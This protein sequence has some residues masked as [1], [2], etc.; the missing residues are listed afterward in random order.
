MSGEN[1]KAVSPRGDATGRQCFLPG[2][3]HH[4]EKNGTRQNRVLNPMPGSSREESA[5]ALKVLDSPG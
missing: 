1:L 3:C 2:K 4:L 5:F